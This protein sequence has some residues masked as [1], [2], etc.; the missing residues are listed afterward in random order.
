LSAEKKSIALRV[1]RCTGTL[2]CGLSEVDAARSRGAPFG[3]GRFV[4]P[5]QP[6]AGPES[7]GPSN[8]DKLTFAGEIGGTP[9]KVPEPRPG[10]RRLDDRAG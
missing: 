5:E 1:R 9:K 6:F 10:E 3:E 8:S 4:T 2:I 7:S